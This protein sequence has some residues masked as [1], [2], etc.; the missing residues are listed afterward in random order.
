MYPEIISVIELI[1]NMLYIASAYNQI[2]TLRIVEINSE[3]E[4]AFV[5]ERDNSVKMI[6]QNPDDRMK[7]AIKEITRLGWH[8]TKQTYLSRAEEFCEGRVRLYEKECHCGDH[9]C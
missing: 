5:D 7:L 1:N 3:K 8:E 2:W 6:F 9:H 4:V